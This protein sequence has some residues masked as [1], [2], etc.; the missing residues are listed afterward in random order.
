MKVKVRLL[1]TTVPLASHGI[2]PDE[3]FLQTSIIPLDQVRRELPLW[4]P[5]AREEV[6][7]LE[8]VTQVVERVTTTTRDIEDWTSQGYKIFQIPGKAVTSCKN[9]TGRRKFRAVACGNYLESQA[10]SST[11]GDSVYASGVDSSTVRL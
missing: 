5:P 8:N 10:P 2:E 4:E 11:A 9:G 7:N 3:L 6:D 1:N